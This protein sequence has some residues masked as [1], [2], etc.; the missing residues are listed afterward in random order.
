MKLQTLIIGILLIA[1]AVMIFLFVREKP[2]LAAAVDQY[3]AGDYREA[4]VILNRIAPAAD[5]SEGE[6][7][8]YYR[9]KSINGLA[10]SLQDHFDDELALLSHGKAEDSKSAKARRRIE[11]KLAS[12]NDDYGTDLTIITTPD[13]SFIE[14]QGTWYRQFI[15][16]YRGSRYIE[17]LEFERIENILQG[18]PERAGE[19]LTAF[20][21]KYPGSDYIGQIVPVV[22]TSFKEGK[23]PAISDKMFMDMLAHYIQRYPT[24]REAGQLFVCNGENVNLRSSPGLDGD[25]LGKIKEDQVLLLREKSVDVVQVGDTR[26][27]WYRIVTLDGLEG[28]IFGSFISP[29]KPE[30]LTEE[31]EEWTFTDDF[32][33]WTDSNTPSQWN[34]L[35]ESDPGTIS[36]T[37]LETSRVLRL[38]SE[39]TQAGLYTRYAVPPAYTL[40]I[41]GRLLAGDA[42]ELVAI[43]VTKESSLVLTFADGSVSIGG[44]TIPVDTSQ[45]HLYRIESDGTQAS[46]AIDGDTVSSR[47]VPEKDERFSERGVYILY[48]PSGKRAIA[49][50]S[51][52]KIR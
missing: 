30:T 10:A 18:E 31:I 9:C 15:N 11:K 2:G 41:R 39:N 25:P 43:T 49:E 38:S 40:E 50:V 35:E 20:L 45:W 46:L 23:P 28:W 13:G 12:L 21:T 5:F 8:A 52:I 6:K 7:I 24:S 37:T 19:V 33:S 44:R 29:W 51:H 32:N 22:L 4:I 16:N 42:V 26:D 3:R 34:H 1:L 27:Y 48:T 36:F 47:I 14:S 17:D